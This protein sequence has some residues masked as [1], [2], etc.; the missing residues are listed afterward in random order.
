MVAELGD[1]ALEGDGDDTRRDSGATELV[2]R[3]RG[4]LRRDCRAKSSGR[5]PGSI[6]S[7]WDAS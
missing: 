4:A 6:P 2:M 1:G 7:R 3:A 5:R